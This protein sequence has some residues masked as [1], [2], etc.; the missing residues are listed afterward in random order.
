MERKS[1]MLPLAAAMATLLMGC[2]AGPQDSTADGTPATQPA[3]AQPS[4]SAQ[5]FDLCQLMPLGDVN[6]ILQANGVAA[7]SELTPHVG[8]ACSYLLRTEHAYPVK[9]LIDFTRM[10]SLDQA[11]V[12]LSAH[13]QDNAIAGTPVIPMQ[14]V[15]D[16]AFVIEREGAE[17][18]KLRAGLYQGQVNLQCDERAPASLRP[19]VVA[20]AKTALDRL[21]K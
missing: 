9:L 2:G 14:G 8:G 15:G 3:P 11:Q 16:E 19:A 5:S 6:A 13:R 18:L 12:A 4:P 1:R 20:L 21:P 7:V 10:R 17:G